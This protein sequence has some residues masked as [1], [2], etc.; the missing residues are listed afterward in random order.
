MT[1]GVGWKVKLNKGHLPY[2]FL[3]IS[4]CPVG[5]GLFITYN[6]TGYNYSEMCTTQQ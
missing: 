3:I 4:K 6:N 5:L 2:T 1:I